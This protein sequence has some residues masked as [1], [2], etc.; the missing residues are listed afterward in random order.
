MV[1]KNELPGV[2]FCVYVCESMSIKY[3]KISDIIIIL[4][5]IIT[6]FKMKGE[7]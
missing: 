5:P 6:L 7:M 2:C 4:Y 3:I 1:I